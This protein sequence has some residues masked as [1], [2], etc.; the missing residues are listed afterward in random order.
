VPWQTVSAFAAGK[1]HDFR[2]KT[3]GPVL[4]KKTGTGMPLRLVVIAPLG[5]RLRKSSRL[6][7]RK[8]AYLL[9]TDPDMPLEELLQDYLWR[10]GIE[11]N[12]REEKT[13]IGTGDAHV[14]TAASNRHL[15][16]VTVAAYS[17]L[18]TVALEAIAAGG[19]LPS[20]DPPK[21]RGSPGRAGGLPSTG[22]L[23]RLLRY[24]TWAGFLRPSTFHHFATGTAPVANAEKP[25]PDLPA[26]LFAAA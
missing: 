3:L 21:W 14:R 18:W 11:V 6:L 22:E 17:L 25:L 19:D 9:C 2:I 4:W 16:A 12:F 8:P 15:S 1:R 23:L 7:Y 20:L 5:Y 24:E 10:W 26:T 13:L